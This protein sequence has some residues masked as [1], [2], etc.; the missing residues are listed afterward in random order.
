MYASDFFIL[1][2]NCIY[3]YDKTLLSIFKHSVLIPVNVLLALTR[4]KQE[5]F[6][7]QSNVLR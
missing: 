5:E 6:T 2:R 7:D 4:T 1:L 3:F